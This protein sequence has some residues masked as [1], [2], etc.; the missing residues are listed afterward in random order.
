[1]LLTHSQDNVHE[2]VTLDVANSGIVF[3]K[4]QLT[5]YACRGEELAAVNFLD[6]F[7][8]TYET[9]IPMAE[10]EAK[11]TRARAGDGD[12]RRGPGR[13]RNARVRYL[14][15]HPKANSVQRVLRCL[16]HRNLP[17]F[18]GRWFPRSD[19]EEEKSFY[20]ASML[21]LLKPWR[22]LAVDLKQPGEK[23]ESAYDD[24]LEEVSWKEKRVISG[25]QYFHE[26]SSAATADDSCDSA[27]ARRSSQETDNSDSEDEGSSPV[28]SALT[29]EGLAELKASSVPYREELHGLL[30]IEVAR[31]AK[32]FRNEASSWSIAT[33]QAPRNAT[34]DDLRTISSWANQLQADVEKK[35]AR[36]PPPPSTQPTQTPS[37]EPVTNRETS[38]TADVSLLSRA[39]ANSEEALDGIDVSHLKPDQAR[40]YR[41]VRWHL[42]QTLNGVEPPPLRMILYGEGGTG[43]S[44]VIQTV[45]EA[46]EARGAKQLLVK[47]AYTGVAA[48]LVDG[49]TTHVIAGVSIHSKG[50]IKDEAKKMLSRRIV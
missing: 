14:P 26:C 20:C 33:T 5:D 21:A 13:P 11:T 45:T 23:W 18:I 22:D 19:E 32:I 16:G 2:T 27:P 25:L 4:C 3:A 41:I 50:S 24:F 12:E 30:A 36:A 28:S 39:L 8:D 10:R 34:D 49:K 9:E 47:A 1:M 31:R 48:S 42:D 17:N 7:V 46:F 44:R 38:S 43:K 37:I 6:F 29:E 40:A 15:H 35:N